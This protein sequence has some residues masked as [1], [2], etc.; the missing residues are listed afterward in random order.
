MK[1]YQPVAGFRLKS[2]DKGYCG[3][4][5]ALPG[6]SA[7]MDETHV[8]V[9]GADGTVRKIPRRMKIVVKAEK[10]PAAMASKS[11]VRGTR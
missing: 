3:P 8:H 4:V 2:E 5:A 11:L 9:N 7:W 6:F 1:N 10:V